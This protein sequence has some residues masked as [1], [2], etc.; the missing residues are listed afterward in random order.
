VARRPVTFF[1]RAKKV[2]KE[3]TPR[4]AALR[5]PDFSG[6]VRAAAQL[7]LRAQTVLA[8]F[9]RSAPEKSAAKKGI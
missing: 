7:A 3:N 4:L 1:A 6:A 9:P 8:D 2:T 5:V